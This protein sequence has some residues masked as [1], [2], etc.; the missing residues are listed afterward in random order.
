MRERKYIPI[1]ELM[2]AY[3][4]LKKGDK[5]SNLA[6][7]RI[8]FGTEK[9]SFEAKGS[10]S[11]CY[12][13][14]LQCALQDAIILELAT[15]P[16][17]LTAMWT[18]KDS[19]SPVYNRFSSIFRDEMSHM[20]MAC[21]LLA[22]LEGE[23]SVTG[24][25]VVPQYPGPLPGGIDPAPDFEVKLQRLTR[26]AIRDFRIIERPKFEILPLPDS[27]DLVPLPDPPDS[28]GDPTIG[29][30]YDAIKA[31]VES[32]VQ[33][34]DIKQERQIEYIYVT[35]V[36]TK[37]EF[38]DAIDK[39]VREGEGLA[40]SPKNPSDYAH[41]YKFTEIACGKQIVENATG[42]WAYSG[43]TIPFPS[44]EDVYPMADVPPDGYDI[45]E[46]FD[47]DRI[48]SEMLCCIEKAW[49]EVDES[50]L[51]TAVNKMR[52]LQGLAQELMQIPIDGSYETYGPCWR[53]DDTASCPDSG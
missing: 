51:R 3:S 20:G 34:G 17:Y 5:N 45:P 23:P 7:Q 11:D 21:N 36:T 52:D 40:D 16:P 1:P 47:F 27:D 2:Q 4:L 53:Y 10:V 50:H 8:I 33:D 39:I 35:K 42:N 13:Q 31:C 41:Y 9:I 48:Y 32:N 15:L 6:A 14:W 19:S 28:N 38:L 44:D 29:D 26:Y 25:D 46:A 43:A 37:Q 12:I 22:A 49:M 18:I 24:Q 30:F